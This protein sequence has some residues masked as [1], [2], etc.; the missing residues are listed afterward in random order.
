[1][2]NNKCINIDNDYLGVDAMTIA[3]LK[4][5][6]WRLREKN[7]TVETSNYIYLLKDVRLAIMGEAGV[8]E[9]TIEK[10]I[11]LMKETKLLKR[12]NRYHFK[13]TAGII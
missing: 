1:M 13:D 5:I 7:L 12:L 10:Y 8:D 6:I 3:R 9:R 2:H 11:K 4:R